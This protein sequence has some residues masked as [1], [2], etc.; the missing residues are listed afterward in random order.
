MSNK[1][2]IVHEPNYTI[3]RVQSDDFCQFGQLSSCRHDSSVCFSDDSGNDALLDALKK[4]EAI[5]STGFELCRRRKIALCVLARS[6]Q[7]RK[8]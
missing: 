5:Y 1:S 8:M 3:Q 2:L 4:G 6:E 7:R